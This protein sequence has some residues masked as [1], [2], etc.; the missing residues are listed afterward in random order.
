MK[1]LRPLIILAVFSSL[2]AHAQN[3]IGT[4]P[5]STPS[6]TGSSPA[7]NQ[8]TS[9]S[10]INSPSMNSN[11]TLRTSPSGLPNQRRNEQQRM[12]DYRPSTTPTSPSSTT[13]AGT[14]TPAM[15]TG[16]P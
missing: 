9:P 6:A 13:P 5:S 11:D 1:I 15:G 7:V 12:E 3:S 16:T 4:S 8:G 10:S 2:V 14:T